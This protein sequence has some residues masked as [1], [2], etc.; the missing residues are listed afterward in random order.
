MIWH[1]LGDVNYRKWHVHQMAW[2][3]EVSEALTA[4]AQAGGPL[5]LVP[6]D[7]TGNMH[8]VII[9]SCSGESLAMIPRD[10]SRLLAMGWTEEEFLLIVLN[11][12][13]A[14]IYDVLGNL[15]QNFL[16][17]APNHQDIVEICIEGSSVAALTDNMKLHVCDDVGIISPTVYSVATGLSA[18]RPVTSIAILRSCFTAS[19]LVEVLVGTSDSVLVVDADGPN[20][21]F[22]Q[23]Y[24]QAPVLSMAVAPNGRFLACFTALG[25]LSVLS[26]SFTTKVLDFDTSNTSKPLE[27]Q[28]CG[29]DSVLL[30]W[31]SFLLMV[32]PYGHWLKFA[33]A[34]PFF[35]IPEVDCCRVISSNTCELLQRV[36]GSIELIHRAGSTEPS[37][38]LYDGTEAFENRTH[39][40]AECLFCGDPLEVS[41]AVE[42]NIAAAAAEIIPAQQKFYLRAAALGSS[43]FRNSDS[44]IAHFV[45]TA[46][47]LRILNQVRRHSPAL[48]L[49]TSQYDQLSP[50]STLV[51]RLLARNH[52]FLAFCISEYLC[53]DCGRVIVH[54]A[55]VKLRSSMVHATL[56]EELGCLLKTRL[57]LLGHSVPSVTVAATADLIGRRQLATTLLEYSE[58][59]T[60]EEVKLL[61]AMREYELALSKAKSSKQVD[62]M[63]LILMTIERSHPRNIAGEAQNIYPVINK[64]LEQEE[65]SNLMRLYYQA[66]SEIKSSVRLHNFFIRDLRQPSFHL[67]GNLALRLSYVQDSRAG[68]L[69]KLREVISLYAQDHDLQF[70][71]RA[72][73]DQVELLELQSVLE[74]KYGVECFFDMSISETIHNL[75]VLA[76]Q[77]HNS[78]SLFSDTTR[79]QRRFRIPERRFVHTK[80]KALAA[81]GQWNALKL[82]S[83][84]KRSIIGYAPY[85]RLCARHGQPMSEIEQYMDRVTST[86]ERWS[87]YAELRLWKP[88]VE[89]SMQAKDNRKL[90][91]IHTRCCD[92]AIKQSIDSY[93][94]DRGG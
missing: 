1:T 74:K 37:A 33:Y 12:G 30:H 58:C 32:G 89:A 94:A 62:I 65:T 22:L 83:L 72:I 2:N 3:V 81:S 28:W 56:D 16:L 18:T 38:V 20:D 36:H 70:Q 67:A 31:N 86:D 14:F 55:C 84:E 90:A 5:A 9:Y 17:L 4:G 6:R 11:D 61:L 69:S 48:C 47:K 77:H 63:Y 21:Q 39:A 42:T 41:S 13:A 23:G 34:A 7:R 25:I 50:A 27:M 46:R 66:H 35:L 75:T 73:E 29:E 60:L 53:L 85:V 57:R 82:M 76:A 80:I 68:R 92:A 44:H 24:L 54:W 52:H 79:L 91:E 43:L 8:K 26:T 93:L 59:S 87:L 10:T 19:G 71:C 78:A 40:Q 45:A 64:I 88:A 15:V 51:D 49:T